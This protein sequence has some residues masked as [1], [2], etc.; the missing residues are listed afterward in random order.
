MRAYSPWLFMPAYFHIK[1]PCSEIFSHFLLLQPPFHFPPPISRPLSSVDHQ[2]SPVTY[3]PLPMLRP[4]TRIPQPFLVV[5]IFPLS[6]TQFP[7]S[8]TTCLV[9]VRLDL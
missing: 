8:A 6:I 4:H 9:I 2:H 7:Y 3:H 5:H 1:L